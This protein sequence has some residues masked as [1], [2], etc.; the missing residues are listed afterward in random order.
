MKKNISIIFLLFIVFSSISYAAKEPKLGDS[1]QK[2]VVER[3]KEY[4]NLMKEFSGDVEKIENMEKIFAICENSNVSVFND[5]A[6]ASARDISDNSMP[7]Q[8]Y[9][10]VLT[11]KFENNVK[12]SYSGFKY[13]KLVVQPSPLKEFDAAQYAFVKVDKQVETSGMKAKQH[14]NIIVNTATMKVSSTISE[15]YEDPQ[16]IYMEALEEFNGGNYKQAIP[17]FEKICSLPRFSGRYRAKS[18]LGWIYAEQKDYQKAN[19][20]LRESSAS[21]PLG[22]IILASKVLLRDDVPVTLRNTTE[23]GTLLMR[24]GDVQDKDF[25]TLHLIAKSALVDAFDIKNLSVKINVTGEMLEKMGEEM[26]SDPASVGAF[27]MRG[28]YL[29]AWD[30]IFSKDAEKVKESLVNINNAENLLLKSNLEKKDFEHWDAQLAILKL[31]IFKKLEDNEGMQSLTK[32]IMLEKPYAAG[33]VAA[34]FILSKDYKRALEFYQKAADYGDPFAAYVV[35][36]SHFPSNDEMTVLEKIYFNQQIRMKDD[37]IKDWP[38]FIYF[39]F[40]DKNLKRSSEDYL[41]WNRIAI[42]LGNENAMEDLAIFEAAGAPPCKERNISHAL[43]LACKAANAGLR[44]K[45]SEKFILVN[46][47]AVNY[48]KESKIPFDKSETYKVLKALDEKGNGAASYLLYGN[49]ELEVKDSEKARYYLERSKDAKFYYGMFDYACELEDKKDYDRAFDLFNEL[50][51]FL[52]S[53]SYGHLGDIEKNHRKNYE[54]ARKYYNKGK[55]EKDY[56]CYEGLSDLSKDGLGCEKNLELAKKYIDLAI[57]YYKL[58]NDPDENNATLKR[59]MEKETELERL[60]AEGGEDAVASSIARLN[61]VIDAEMGEDERV[62]L[63]QEL[64]SVVFTSPKAVVKT[65]GSNGKT[66]VST[67]TAE[68]FMLRLATLKTDKRI[69]EVTSKKDKDNK[70]TELT[71]QMK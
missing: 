48:E 13:V 18:M 39:L 57:G 62:T 41:K 3:V 4:C 12:T 65:V 67:E 42:D 49:F 15:D 38:D 68:D 21:D 23:A 7:L 52:Y 9:M 26:V 14:L 44:G 50:T 11:D 33:F 69:V 22:G 56:K 10:M 51:A 36:L 45:V 16:R 70:Y 32:S 63:S 71:V 5:L 34:G 43:D 66:I 24:L 1:A 64:L 40:T 28:Y 58:D 20:L 54:N 59:L 31:F 8:Q 29:K 46:Y 19:D 37:F 55:K 61:Q 35:S 6:A 17:L 2:Q 27:K 53:Y 25:P 47:L 30:G 60:I